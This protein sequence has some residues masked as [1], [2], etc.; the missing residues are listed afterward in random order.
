[1]E[2]WDSREGHNSLQ[3][4]QEDGHH[5]K[6]HLDDVDETDS[7]KVEPGG[8]PGGEGGLKDG[9]GG[10]PGGEAQSLEAIPQSPEAN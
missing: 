5:Q 2:S 3:E 1:M 10:E 6:S 4:G 9:P 8:D 7:L